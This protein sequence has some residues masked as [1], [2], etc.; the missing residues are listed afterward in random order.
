M[1]QAACVTTNPD[2]YFSDSP[3]T[4]AMKEICLGCPVFQQC[5]VYSVINEEYGYWAAT[6][7]KDRRRIR[8]DQ[9]QMDLILFSPFATLTEYHVLTVRQVRF[10]LEWSIP[11]EPAPQLTEAE[12]YL[13]DHLLDQD[14]EPIPNFVL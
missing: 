7:E 6:T 3:P 11:Y 13:L 5:R 4:E 12:R 14:F 8:R 2:D 1:R 9:N 10:H